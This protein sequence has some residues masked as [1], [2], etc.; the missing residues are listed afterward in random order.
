M[1]IP[2]ISRSDFPNPEMDSP[3]VFDKKIL[4][5]N[6]LPS[7]KNRPEAISTLAC[8][9]ID[10]C[11][12]N[13]MST[14]SFWKSFSLQQ[15]EFSSRSDPLTSRG[16]TLSLVSQFQL[17]ILKLWKK[18][19]G[20]FFQAQLNNQ[21]IDDLI[22]QL[23][24]YIH[25]D[26]LF[27]NPKISIGEKVKALQKEW[28][29]LLKT[30]P[31]YLPIGYRGGKIQTGH[32]ITLK[33]ELINGQVIATFFNLGDGGSLH[34][35][36]DKTAHANKVSFRYFPIVIEASNFFGKDGKAAFFHLLRYCQDEPT[37]NAPPYEARELYA[38]L[39]TLGT[40]KPEFPD[41][42]FKIYGRFPQITG[43]CTVL[44]VELLIIDRLVTLDYPDDAIEKIMLNFHLCS[45]IQGHLALLKEPKESYLRFF[46][47]SASV[48]GIEIQN[49]KDQ[50]SEK[51]FICAA[52]LLI[53]LLSQSYPIQPPKHLFVYEET[54][55]PEIAPQPPPTRHKVFG[56]IIQTY[57]ENTVPLDK[58]KRLISFQKDFD[59]LNAAAFFLEFI[60]QTAEL[61]EREKPA[62]LFE[63]LTSLPIPKFREEDVWDRV[64]TDQIAPTIQSLKKILLAKLSC[65][66]DFQTSRVIPSLLYCI[67]DKL[68]RR[69]IPQLAGYASP[70][71]FLNSVNEEKVLTIYSGKLSQCYG[72]V[73]T[74]FE[75]AHTDG[76]PHQRGKP[77]IFPI[78]KKIS[79]EE[80]FNNLSEGKTPCHN[81]FRFLAQFAPMERIYNLDLALDLWQG[82]FLP[83]EV[84]E[85]YIFAFIVEPSTTGILWS[86][87]EGKLSLAEIFLT[88]TER[89]T[90]ILK[91]K[92][93]YLPFSGSESVSHFPL[94]SKQVR[95]TDTNAAI[96]AEQENYPNLFMDVHSD[97]TFSSYLRIWNLQTPNLRFHQLLQWIRIH[98]Y[99]SCL[100][101]FQEILTYTLFSPRALEKA[102]SRNSDLAITIRETFN[103]LISVYTSQPTQTTTLEFLIC[104]GLILETHLYLNAPSPSQEMLAQYSSQLSALIQSKGALNLDSNKKE[105]ETTSIDLFPWKILDF[106]LQTLKKDKSLLDWE[107]LIALGYDINFYS[108]LLYLPTYE[109]FSKK[110]KNLVN[111]SIGLNIYSIYRQKL[112]QF[113]EGI[114]EIET[115]QLCSGLALRIFESKIEGKWTQENEFIVN[116]NAKF[117]FC[118]F[119]FKFNGI[120]KSK[121]PNID[122]ETKL[123]PE[124]NA[125]TGSWNIEGTCWTS[126]ERNV[127][128]IPTQ[129]HLRKQ[130]SIRYRGENRWIEDGYFP[131]PQDASWLTCFFK[132][133]ECL[134]CFFIAK[135]KGDPDFL[136]C[137]PKNGIPLYEVTKV[138][139]TPPLYEISTLSR[140]GE[141][142]NYLVAATTHPDFTSASHPFFRFAPPGEFYCLVDKGTHLVHELS[143]LNGEIH[144]VRNSKGR[145]ECLQPHPGYYLDLEVHPQGLGHFQGAMVLTNEYG[146]LKTVI[147]PRYLFVEEGKKQNSITY[148]DLIVSSS[149]TEKPL[150]FTYERLSPNSDFSC[151]NPLGYLY[152]AYVLFKQKNYSEAVKYLKKIQEKDFPHQNTHLKGFLEACFGVND[153]S[154]ESICLKTRL[155]YLFFGYERSLK[156]SHFNTTYSEP[157]S[158]IE[159]VCI[160]AYEEYLRITGGEKHP[161]TSRKF[162][163]SK[164]EEKLILLHLE[165]RYRQFSPTFPQHFEERLSLL[166]YKMRRG[167]MD[168]GTIA[169]PLFGLDVTISRP[170]IKTELF[171]CQQFMRLEKEGDSLKLPSF[172]IR[173]TTEQILSNF[174]TL[175]NMALGPNND[176][177][178][179]LLLAIRNKEGVYG[180]PLRETLAFILTSAYLDPWAFKKDCSRLLKIKDEDLPK[181]KASTLFQL[182]N[183]C[184]LGLPPKKSLQFRIPGSF[185]IYSP[186]VY[187][188]DDIKLSPEEFSYEKTPLSELCEIYFQAVAS[189]PSLIQPLPKLKKERLPPI[190]LSFLEEYATNQPKE[191]TN[192]PK[193]KLKKTLSLLKQE[194]T[195]LKTKNQNQLLSLQQEIH[196]LF[197]VD[198][199]LRSAPFQTHH[200]VGETLDLLLTR[201]R[202][203]IPPL[204]P[205]EIM[206][207]VI[208]KNR[209]GWLLSTFP[210]LT[211]QQI[212]ELVCKTQEFFHLQV[213]ELLINHC[214]QK[215]DQL[216][217]NP[218]SP[219]HLLELYELLRFEF[220][221][222]PNRYPEISAFVSKTSKLLRPKQV[223]I[224]VWQCKQIKKS[225][226][227]LFQGRAGLGKS[228]VLTPLLILRLL[229]E[230]GLPFVF[231]TE[232]MYSIYKENLSATLSLLGIQLGLLEVGLHTK[233]T[234]EKLKLIAHQLFLSLEDK[235]PILLTP[236]TYYA[237]KLM[238]W[239]A[240]YYEAP[241]E[242]IETLAK[243]LHLI[244][245]KVFLICDE[246]HVAF[247]A[248]TTAIYGF[249][250]LKQ[251]DQAAYPV[252][253]DLIYPLVGFK[254]LQIQNQSA[255]EIFQ[256]LQNMNDD[257]EASKTDIHLLSMLQ[258]ALSETI[259]PRYLQRNLKFMKIKNLD[260]EIAL[261][262][263]FVQKM[264]AA[265]PPSFEA[266]K[267]YDKKSADIVGYIRFFLTTLLPSITQMRVSR[268][269][270]VSPHR[271]LEFHTP[272]HKG[273][274]STAQYR[275]AL[276]TIVTTIKGVCEKGL[277]VKQVLFHIEEEKK[278]D[279]NWLQTQGCGPLTLVSPSQ[280]RFQEWSAGT[281]FEGK[282][283]SEVNLADKQTKKQL[284]ASFTKNKTLISYV[285]TN[286]VLPQIKLPEHEIQVASPDLVAVKK[287]FAFSATPGHPATLPGDFAQTLYDPVQTATALSKILEDQNTTQL[288]AE[289]FSPPE[290]FTWLRSDQ[291]VAFEACRVLIDMAGVFCHL[292]NEKIAQLWLQNSKLQGILFFHKSDSGGFKK[293][294]KITFLFE[295]KG[296]FV[297][298]SFEGSHIRASMETLGFDFT[299]IGIYY[300]V[301]HSESADI[302]LFGLFPDFNIFFIPGY[303]DKFTAS[304]TIQAVMRVRDFL[305]VAKKRT[306]VWI[307]PKAVVPK[308]L[309]RAS[310]YKTMLINETK[311]SRTQ[312]V[313]AATQGIV[314]SIR[315]LIE[316][317][318][319][320]TPYAQ[321]KGLSAKE[322][323]DRG[324]RYRKGFVQNHQKDPLQYCLQEVE[325]P[326]GPMLREFSIRFAEQSGVSLPLPP[327]CQSEI[328]QIIQRAEGL[329]PN[330][331]TLNLESTS[332]EVQIEM[333]LDIDVQHEQEKQVHKPK[334]LNPIT[335][336]WEVGEGIRIK[337]PAFLKTAKYKFS[338]DL[339]GPEITPFYFSYEQLNTGKD[340]DNPLFEALMKPI[341][342]FIVC[343]NADGPHVIAQ[344][345]GIVNTATV[346]LDT[347]YEGSE[348][349]HRAL[350]M[351]GD[352][353]VIQR[354]KDKM[355]PTH[356][357]EKNFFNSSLFHN[358]LIDTAFLELSIPQNPS[359]AITRIANWGPSFINFF[360]KVKKA[361]YYKPPT[362]ALEHIIDLALKRKQIKNK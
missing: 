216:S 61:S 119:T 340:N 261:Y 145:L 299:K 330:E 359:N 177:F 354:G 11:P 16:T 282:K 357:E 223:D 298:R 15:A 327:D 185:T 229:R 345:N 65:P 334:P 55:H 24:R 280:K 79:V 296:E 253:L 260:E 153:G 301:S 190:A 123:E 201:K 118:K 6:K 200:E 211:E 72:A 308:A 304:S 244:N 184:P 155:T 160:Q 109:T 271:N 318:L 256:L 306:L 343:F 187:E 45:L 131:D 237:L 136:L 232:A 209:S 217:P 313:L 4:S 314:K 337:D 233:V 34:P 210:L 148:T 138:E 189:P 235:H 159:A 338:Q 289:T 183:E 166:I 21:H 23:E 102:L 169:T 42:R 78:E 95:E 126:D 121:S 230:E 125:N 163:L 353:K 347:P 80:H 181:L 258:K 191:R 274:P 300:D 46:K 356:E 58:K 13:E 135:K 143:F 112:S 122:I 75:Q 100:P 358:L 111:Q 36:V 270:D 350:I 17:N 83:I 124:K 173:I 99:D 106:F 234:A 254:P 286:H 324:E 94:F 196:L 231:T 346:D 283:L 272:Y 307:F 205:E 156:E 48:L 317:E 266:L 151:P 252:Y 8:W 105:G 117:N 203:N 325:R 207:E 98:P 221:Y 245:S 222:N 268:D 47:E 62:Y 239:Q 243:I 25:Y 157:L 87:D 218:E 39:H 322:Q 134:P 195:S 215:V 43:N 89:N 311:L 162:L 20:L 114:S 326:L 52:S 319:I 68:V 175:L 132:D 141:K 56:D 7:T 204:T 128:Y 259:L 224:H 297:S 321:R 284:V 60:A 309:S 149:A 361:Y 91:V 291:L 212:N 49:L 107:N 73:C 339:F 242:R 67:S 246:L 137:D 277:T 37:A 269:H 154:I 35:V 199:A 113:L 180:T 294:E 77:V 97:H 57:F 108:K 115:E 197:S 176:S 355:R 40:L 219:Q 12:E 236:S 208:L 303:N 287:V 104:T 174:F 349:I 264:D 18:K 167:E 88:T 240:L 170:K 362:A 316:S 2:F 59:P 22:L 127:R 248:D 193:L 81:H 82:K 92:D 150:F 360:E 103:H 265:A 86:R 30:G 38:I 220:R 227:S 214:L 288:L 152:L 69:K 29:E 133:K 53:H 278:E 267:N 120:T 290:F 247:A 202:G 28:A 351:T 285:L 9:I 90:K 198:V 70:F 328:D 171:F 101:D 110:M 74:Y 129:Q 228:E 251:E 279:F 165:D 1:A 164:E 188:P 142:T 85:L 336:V 96:I 213:V 139:T 146:T 140:S 281:P 51:E 194:L 44:A 178:K 293:E 292:S 3:S 262:C 333:E 76:Q 5:Y 158:P 168:A 147:I 19:A 241:S 226:A 238:Y 263:R 93:S 26:A 27:F 295:E 10:Q 206:F 172:P 310:L 275:L 192:P 315:T 33:L 71:P 335:P 84:N 276:Q 225:G 14:S 186:F 305:D 32:A 331:S 63:V 41:Q 257:R 320:Y 302:P 54:P 273:T 255:Q 64:P 144:F 342:F 329:V 182:I 31:I 179:Y 312:I 344:Y 352:G 116:K 332:Q 250:H 323:K 249:G 348:P 161:L 341:D 130:I 66:P 50:M